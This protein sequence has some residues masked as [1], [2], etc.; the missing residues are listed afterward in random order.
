MG[1]ITWKHPVALLLCFYIFYRDSTRPDRVA[2][3]VI[4]PGQASAEQ[5]VPEPAPV[6]SPGPIESILPPPLKQEAKASPAPGNRSCQEGVEDE[7]DNCKYYAQRND[8]IQY[9]ETVDRDT[10]I[11]ALAIA[12][13]ESNLSCDAV[14]P[15][16]RAAGAFQ[17]MPENIIP[18]ATAAGVDIDPN[19][20][21]F[22]Q[23]VSDCEAQV[24]IVTHRINYYRENVVSGAYNCRVPVG[25]G[26]RSEAIL[27]V[28][29]AW[30]SG[31]PCL[32]HHEA[33]Q[34]YDGHPYPSIAD[35]SR[36]VQGYAEE[37]GANEVEYLAT[38]PEARGFSEMS[39]I[40][41]AI[42]RISI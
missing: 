34:Y 17:V 26:K 10:R 38:L 35:Y 33:T 20:D 24:K 14:N 15:H 18:W 2:Q 1:G 7:F 28:A 5:P 36:H 21:F 12:T 30:Y 4:S 6:A 39:Y 9:L 27:R 25:S 11:I 8:W 29:S 16:S 40:R 23:F 37:I 31:D 42:E 3:A 22:S 19:G 41:Q 32:A 13:Q